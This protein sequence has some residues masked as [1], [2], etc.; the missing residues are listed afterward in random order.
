MNSYEQYKLAELGFLNELVSRGVSADLAEMAI[1]DAEYNRMQ[2]ADNESFME[3][4]NEA[5]SKNMMRKKAQKV[6]VLNDDDEDGDEDE[7]AI[8]RAPA[9]RQN[10]NLFDDDWVE[11]L[12]KWGRYAGIFGLGALA[13]YATPH[14]RNIVSR[15]WS[16]L[17]DVYGTKG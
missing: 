8:T 15:G 1:K 17:R 3:G 14:V 10:R 11:K 7:P 2:Q 4:F 9:V 13:G 16:G 6:V 5:M 12:K